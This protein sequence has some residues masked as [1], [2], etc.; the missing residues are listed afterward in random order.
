MTTPRTRATPAIT[1]MA[2]ELAVASW[3][4]ITHRT[5]MMAFNQCTP[6]E[7]QRMVME[8]MAAAQRSGA[9]YLA[10]WGN[11]DPADLLSPWHRGAVANA[12]R[13]SRKA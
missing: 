11:P 1:Q 6:M 12:K 7:Y 9:T 13:L 5:M 8:K 4:V 3:Q 2:F 10:A